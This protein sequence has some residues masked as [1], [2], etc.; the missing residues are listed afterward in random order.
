MKYL[1]V[2]ITFLIVII[3]ISGCPKPCIE[4]NYSFAVHSQ[5]IPDSDS[6]KVGDTIFLSS[7]FPTILTD[8][9]TGQVIDYNNSIDLG[10]TLGLVE[11]VKGIYPGIDAVNDFDYIS[12][13]GMAYN[14][15]SIASP[16]KFQQ[17]KYEQINGN[18]ELKIGVIPKKNGTYYLGLGDGLSNGR[19]KNK[20]CEKASFNITFKNTNQHLNYFSEWSSSTILS[21]Y[22]QSHAYFFKVY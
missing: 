6:I 7:S 21:A 1:I 17:L 20:S 13:S 8:Q 12:I 9:S 2:S 4:S 11:L 18:Y 15:K 5:I 22:E 10:S 3:V 14:D 19:N 16:N